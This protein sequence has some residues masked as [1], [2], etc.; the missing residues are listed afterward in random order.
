MQTLKTMDRL[1]LIPKISYEEFDM[2]EICVEAKHAKTSF[3]Q[4]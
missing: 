2:C 1:R 4:T 3:K